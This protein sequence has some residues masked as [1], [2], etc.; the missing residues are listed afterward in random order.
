M[1]RNKNSES[2]LNAVLNGT[3]PW[4]ADQLLEELEWWIATSQKPRVDS[5]NPAV[6][7][8]VHWGG[9]VEGIQM[10]QIGL[11]VKSKYPTELWQF[12]LA[13]LIRVIDFPN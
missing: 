12:V 8:A 2:G 11:H 3:R 9:K 1:T 5:N 13:R 6:K 10:K 4:N 7:I